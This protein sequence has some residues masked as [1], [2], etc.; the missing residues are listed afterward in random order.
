MANGLAN[1]VATF[2]QRIEEA[3]SHHDALIGASVED[4]GFSRPHLMVAIRRCLRVDFE[5]DDDDALDI[6]F[7]PPSPQPIP[8]REA[9]MCIP[10]GG[11]Q[12]VDAHDDKGILDTIIVQPP[13]QP[14]SYA[15]AVVSLL[16]G[17][18]NRRP[19]SFC[20]IVGRITSG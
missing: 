6:A 2:T 12:W 11:H 1:P 3:C 8:Y 9:V 16:G 13:P 5:D 19:P 7:I 4:F 15:E 17:N 10:G 18:I 20:R 14:T